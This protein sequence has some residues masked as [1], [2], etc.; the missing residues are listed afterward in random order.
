MAETHLPDAHRPHSRTPRGWGTSIWCACCLQAK[1]RIVDLRSCS[2]FRG[3]GARRP[4]LRG[5]CAKETCY[6]ASEYLKLPINDSC[7]LAAGN[8]ETGAQ[9]LVILKGCVRMTRP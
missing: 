6:S 3:R 5:L 4:V 9:H 7:W 8:T 1:T 2:W